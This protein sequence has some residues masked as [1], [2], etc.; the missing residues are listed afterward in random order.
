MNKQDSVLRIKCQEYKWA[1]CV[2]SEQGHKLR[3]AV[4]SLKQ[5]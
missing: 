5:Y 2:E 3:L 1:Q 4:D